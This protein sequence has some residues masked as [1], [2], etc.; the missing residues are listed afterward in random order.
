MIDLSMIIEDI[1]SFHMF[2]FHIYLI[3][4]LCEFFRKFQIFIEL[5]H[6]V[7]FDFFKLFINE[8]YNEFL[9]IYYSVIKYI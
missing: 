3:F 2:H 6:K 4:F 7:R 5:F 9:F 8:F 1:H